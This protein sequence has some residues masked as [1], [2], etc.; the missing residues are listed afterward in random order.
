MSTLKPTIAIAGATGNLGK[1]VTNAFLEPTTL[2]KFAA[3]VLLSRKRSSPVLDAWKDKGAK[4]VVCAEDDI[5]EALRGVD[6]L[7]NTEFGMD[8]YIHDFLHPDWDAKKHHYARAQEVL[9]ST[10]KICRVFIGQLLEISIGPWYGF[11]TTDGEYEAV[12]S[13]ETKTSYT[14]HEDAG[15]VVAALASMN[16]AQAPTEVRISGHAISMTDIAA[17]MVRAGA[18]DVE[19]RTVDGAAF[20]KKTIEDS[21]N[22]PS[23]YLRFLM[24]DGRIDRSNVAL[25]NENELVNPGQTLWK[26]KGNGEVRKGN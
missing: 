7:V 16:V 10:T 25:G 2:S 17:L 23:Q 14:A 24:G 13:A 22:D 9:P 18:G 21:A 12:G 3:I 26:W 4:I 19:M 6:M 8:H 5:E 11:N 15:L 20:R 1:D